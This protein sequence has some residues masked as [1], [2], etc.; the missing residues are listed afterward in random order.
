[1]KTRIFSSLGTFIVLIL[2]VVSLTGCGTAPVIEQPVEAVTSPPLDVPTTEPTE[3]VVVPTTFAIISENGHTL[4]FVW[5]SEFSADGAL[6]APNDVA[7]DQE[8]NVYVSAQGTPKIKKFDNQGKFVDHWGAFGSGEGQFSYTAGLAIDAQGNIYVADIGGIEI[9]KFDSAG[10]FLLGWAT[11]PPAGP[12][13]VVVDHNGYAYVDNFSTHEHH[14]Q[15]FDSSGNLVLSWGESGSGEGQI[16]SQPEDIAVDKDGNVYVADRLNHSIQK[17]D[18]EGNFLT[19][20]G[21]EASED[22]NGRFYEPRGIAIDNEGNLY[23]TDEHFLQNLDP[24]GNLIAQWPKTEGGALDR[25]GLLAV[26]K[27]GNLY[28]LAYGEVTSTTGETVSAVLVKKF[29]QH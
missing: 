10:N 13:S 12:A 28:I 26:D 8:G 15:K 17:F 19:R 24:E 23:V 11:E 18:S 4:T 16:G 14:I 1:M 7:V 29:S 2:L 20:F 3:P 25:A 6:V 22:G 21:G 27:Q 5:Q 9:E